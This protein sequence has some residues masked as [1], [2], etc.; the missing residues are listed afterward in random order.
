MCIPWIPIDIHVKYLRTGSTRRVFKSS[1]KIGFVAVDFL[2]FQ[3]ALTSALT[4]SWVSAHHKH[5]DFFPLYGIENKRNLCI[6]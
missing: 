1:L 6:H 5:G 2:S 3:V 4:W